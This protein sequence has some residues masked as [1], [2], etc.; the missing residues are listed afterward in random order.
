MVI[1][2]GIRLLT[3]K[4]YENIPQGSI[5][6]VKDWWMLDDKSIENDDMWLRVVDEKGDTFVD[7]WCAAA[8]MGVR[9]VLEIK[10]TDLKKGDNFSFAGREW[11][12]FTENLALCR[13]IIAHVPA[14]DVNAYFLQDFYEY[15]KR[16]IIICE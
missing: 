16:Q 2:K 9:P 4:E 1:I 10:Y 6:V 14:A 11:D 13:E 7:G 12:L 3:L 15:W 5:C 8:Y